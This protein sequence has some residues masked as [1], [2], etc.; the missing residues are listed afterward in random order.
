MQEGRCLPGLPSTHHPTPRRRHTGVNDGVVII[1]EAIARVSTDGGPEILI[2]G[3]HLVT[4]EQT[5]TIN[6]SE[7]VNIRKALKQA[8]RNRKVTTTEH[9]RPRPG[10]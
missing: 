7:F 4:F 9:R 6:G 1:N 5:A 8:T 10:A 3:T 2:E